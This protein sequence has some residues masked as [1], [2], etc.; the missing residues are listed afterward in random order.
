MG[1]RGMSQPEP[2]DSSC[3]LGLLSCSVPDIPQS[4]ELA[5]IIYN[6]FAPIRRE[7]GRHKSAA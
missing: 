6:L 2:I 7:E 4:S 3:K 5:P 1:E